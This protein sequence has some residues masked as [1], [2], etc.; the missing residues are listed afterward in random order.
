MLRAAFPEHTYLGADGPIQYVV[1][2][3]ALH[4][5]ALDTLVPGAEHGELDTQRL[6]WLEAA[7]A[8]R[9]QQPNM[10]FMHH[11]AFAT[12]IIEMDSGCVRQAAS[13]WALLARHPQVKRVSCGHVH[14]AV[15]AQQQGL[16]A[17]I[18]PSTAAQLGLQLDVHTELQVTDEPVGFLLHYTVSHDV[19]THCV[20]VPARD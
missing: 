15:F 19:L 7:L 10:V 13:F 2:H 11:P 5:I 1:E 6:A 12:G 18:A 16:P 3:R 17:C 8:A 14:R 4:C 20:W 9:A